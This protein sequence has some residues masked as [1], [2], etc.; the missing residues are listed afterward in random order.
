V[1][2]VCTLVGRTEPIAA[3]AADAAAIAM[4][5]IGHARLQRLSTGTG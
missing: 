3:D 2:L 4:T 1:R 5:H